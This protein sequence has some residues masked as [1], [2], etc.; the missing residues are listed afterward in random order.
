MRL[1]VFSSGLRLSH[2]RKLRHRCARKSR[3]RAYAHGLIDAAGSQRSYQSAPGTIAH[4]NDASN[5]NLNYDFRV[6][7][8]H[9]S[10][11]S[12]GPRRV[13]SAVA[14]ALRES[15]PVARLSSRGGL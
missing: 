12:N 15:S 11:R 9:R 3:E 14:D 4:A 8:V 6:S 10:R 5:R 7:Q 1:R 13:S 2:R